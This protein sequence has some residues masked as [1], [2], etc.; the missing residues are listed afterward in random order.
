[1]MPLLPQILDCIFILYYVL[2]LLLKVFALGPRG[3]LSYPSNVCD[4]LLTSILLVKW[5][6]LTSPGLPLHP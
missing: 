1:M 6:E 3:Y 2:E 5:E 4:G